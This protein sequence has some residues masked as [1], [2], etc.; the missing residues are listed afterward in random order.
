MDDALPKYLEQTPVRAILEAAYRSSARNGLM[1]EVAYL[2]GLRVSELVKLSRDDYKRDARRIRISQSKGSHSG[3]YPVFEHLIPRLDAHLAARTDKMPAL[4][5]GRQGR[6][7][8]RQVQLIFDAA[9]VAA[10]VEL[11][12]GQGIHSLRHSIAVHLMEAEWDIVDVQKHL[13]HRRISSTQ[14]YAQISDRRRN[15]RIKGL[16]GNSKIVTVQTS[17]LPSAP[18]SDS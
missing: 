2:Y 17:A 14:I 4:F 18:R 13:G 16:A 8:T 9:A 11:H 5:P 1:L 6:L 7:S 10:G 12:N 15:E 3:E